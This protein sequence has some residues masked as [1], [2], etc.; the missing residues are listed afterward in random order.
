[1]IHNFNH[2]INFLS[3]EFLL[4]LTF[5]SPFSASFCLLLHLPGVC[6]PLK[7]VSTGFNRLIE[8]KGDDYAPDIH[9]QM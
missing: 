7:P 1:M 3:P 2:L 6:K 8:A 5:F 4:K 9:R